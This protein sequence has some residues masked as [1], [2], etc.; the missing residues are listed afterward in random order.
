LA[1]DLRDKLRIP[2]PQR[3]ERPVNSIWRAA[4]ALTPALPQPVG[5]SGPAHTRAG[6]SAS[7]ANTERSRMPPSSTATARVLEL[8]FDPAVSTADDAM[9]QRIL[10]AALELAAA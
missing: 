3:D 10:D 9:S 4:R 8:A 5:V 1:P 2:W 7:P 6:R